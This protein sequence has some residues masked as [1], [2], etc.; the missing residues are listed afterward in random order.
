M[1]HTAAPLTWGMPLLVDCKT[2]K[3]AHLCRGLMG[4]SAGVGSWRAPAP[5]RGQGKRLTSAFCYLDGS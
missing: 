4:L 3:P 5:G 1:I 2:P